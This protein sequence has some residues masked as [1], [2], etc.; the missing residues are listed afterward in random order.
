MKDVYLPF[1]YIRLETV[2]YTI[3]TVFWLFV[4]G[5]VTLF[6]PFFIYNIVD[7]AMRKKGQQNLEK[8][9]LIVFPD[10]QLEERTRW[11]ET[12]LLVAKSKMAA[13]S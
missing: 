9:L 6:V 1:S 11:L 10:R 13:K 4:I 8:D 12:Q 5:T 3:G 7:P 2:V